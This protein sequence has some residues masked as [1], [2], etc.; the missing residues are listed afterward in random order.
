MRIIITI[1]FTTICFLTCF[2][3]PDFIKSIFPEGTVYYQNIQY[4][5][6]TLK[7][8]R[9]D[10]YQPANTTIHTPVV[11]W[12]H[13]GAWKVNDKY[14]DMSYMKNTLKSI[15]ESGYAL[16]SIDYRH[17]TSAIFP[18]QIEDCYEALQ[19]LHDHAKQYKLDPS[20]FVLMGFSAGGHLASL[21]ALSVNNKVDAFHPGKKI[22]LSVKGVVDFYGP[23]DFLLFYGMARPGKD[24]SPIGTLLGASP[25]DRPDLSKAAS[26]V[27]YV[28]KNDPPFLIVHGEKDPD[29]PV[30][31]SYLLK[32]YLD[33]ANVQNEL[34]VVK[35]AP[36]Y[37]VMFDVDDVRL[38]VISFLKDRFK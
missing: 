20:K 33:L 4:A 7:K 19:Y 27:T 1:A 17:S 37:G 29:V 11:V 25:L 6:D 36:H 9:L 26:P 2:A 16:A 35:D 30:A 18:A 15:L 13:G 3:Q 10:I 31:Q 21:L 5:S 8:H 24:E 32:S 22:S 23:S 14:A 28:D 38:K 12:V 34:I